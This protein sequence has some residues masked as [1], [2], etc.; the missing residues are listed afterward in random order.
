MSTWPYKKQHAPC[1]SAPAGQYR[2]CASDSDGL[3]S[4]T[5]RGSASRLLL[6]VAAAAV[7]A[8]AVV[9]AGV[10]SAAVEVEFPRK[11]DPN[12]A[13]NPPVLP[14]LA[15]AAGELEDDS[16][17]CVSSRRIPS[18]QILPMPCRSRRDESRVSPL[19][20]TEP[21]GRKRSTATPAASPELSMQLTRMS[22]T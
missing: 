4:A 6:E 17:G 20:T 19:R 3:S 2:P 1:R 7:V 13:I 15:A 16:A 14:L 18:R 8:A 21:R 9:A 22:C 12:L 5:P 10:V 11:K